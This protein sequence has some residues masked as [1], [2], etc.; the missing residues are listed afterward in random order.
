M[1]GF[2]ARSGLEEGKNILGSTPSMAVNIL[3]AIPNSPLL[4]S[5]FVGKVAK[6]C[7]HSLHSHLSRCLANR[8][9]YRI[10]R[11]AAPVPSITE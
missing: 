5:L 1:N 9:A 2:L 8:P 7:S 3:K 6:P 4:A 11:V 10:L